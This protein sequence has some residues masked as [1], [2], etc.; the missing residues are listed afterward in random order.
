M[1][2]VGEFSDLVEK[3]GASMCLFEEAFKTR[4][5]PGKSAP[6]VAEKLGFEHGCRDGG[7]I[8]SDKG[9][10]RMRSTAVNPAGQEFF[11]RARFSRY[12]DGVSPPG[13]GGGKGK[14]GL[15]AGILRYKVGKCFRH[16]QG[17]ITG[18]A[19]KA[20]H[21]AFPLIRPL[22]GKKQ[23]IV[24][25]GFDKVI[26]GPQ[27]H[28]GN[29]CRYVIK[30][31]NNY[32]FRVGLVRFGGLEYFQA[33]HFRH[34]EIEENDVVIFL[35]DETD[36][37]PTVVTSID[38]F[39]TAPFEDPLQRGECY[40]FIIHDEDFHSLCLPISLITSKSC[41]IEKGFFKRHLASPIMSCGVSH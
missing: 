25:H 17:L 35:P 7:Y 37:Q 13:H 31:R 5:C 21:E 28:G 2:T 18:D 30:G 24:I 3:Q 6:H 9:T 26:V 15:H 4:L 41:S 33:V 11:T 23:K 20:P 19:R 36:R 38:V 10:F 39:E 27:T 1:K 16:F 14:N 32:E 40:L 8:H 12:E 34:Y 29:R 22:Y